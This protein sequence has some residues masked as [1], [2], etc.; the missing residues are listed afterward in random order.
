MRWDLVRWSQLEKTT[1]TTIRTMMQTIIMMER[2]LHNPVYEYQWQHLKTPRFAIASRDIVVGEVL[3]VEKAI[4]SHMLP[5]YMVINN[6]VF[7]FKWWWRMFVSRMR[8]WTRLL[9]VFSPRAQMIV[10]VLEQKFPDEYF[11]QGRN[12]THCFKSMK[13][14]LP[15]PFCTKVTW[16]LSIIFYKTI[17]KWCH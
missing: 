7:W 8:P 12:C 14:P 1:M 5:E 17:F 6:D 3:C 4:V 9:F 13:A 16:T 15:C 2:P 10:F 11:F